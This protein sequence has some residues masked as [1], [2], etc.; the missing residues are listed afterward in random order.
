MFFKTINIV[1]IFNL[2]LLCG[3]NNDDMTF[4][5]AINILGNAKLVSRHSSQINTNN[6]QLYEAQGFLINNVSEKQ[7]V[8]L[9]NSTNPILKIYA[10]IALKESK[11]NVNLFDILMKHIHD[12]REVITDYSGPYCT[13]AEVMIEE[14]YNSTLTEIDKIKLNKYCLNNNI[15]H[16]HI[17]SLLL[18]GKL[19]ND[20]YDIIKKLLKNN[21]GPA[22][23]ALARY[24][25]EENIEDILAVAINKNIS[26]DYVC[27]AISE[28]PHKLFLVYL[29]EHTKEI[30]N[31]NDSINYY[32]EYYKAVTAFE[33]KEANE[34][35]WLIINSE[36][37]DI[38]NDRCMGHL[39]NAISKHLIPLNQYI[40]FYLM[41]SW[42]KIN[43]DV[44]KFLLKTDKERTLVN[45]ENII[46]NIGNGDYDK[47]LDAVEEMI[48]ILINNKTKD[49]IVNVLN[50]GVVS[51]NYINIELITKYIIKMKSEK[52]IPYLFNRL[53]RN[54]K[55]WNNPNSWIYYEVSKA[56]LSYKNKEYNNKYYKLYKAHK[57]KLMKVVARYID[58]MIITGE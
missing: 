43:C 49:K 45:I 3:I 51:A 24:R 12:D 29:K 2:H 27:A 4:D 41:E 53:T 36:N 57:P 34:L 54:E 6:N 47:K 17:R 42:N 5:K 58:N 33:S 37:R 13:V 10:F 9:T 31:N 56:I 11:S 19:K 52:S 23:V 26:M 32:R 48:N 25:K 55:S 1:F 40:L 14:L 30:L 18:Y 22:L 16:C 28:F 21:Y 35:I 20:Y 50:E 38:N 44:I 46:A 39:F 8:D 7:L 15:N